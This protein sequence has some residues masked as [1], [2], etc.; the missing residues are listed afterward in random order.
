MFGSTF[1][2]AVDRQA[3]LVPDR[4]VFANS[5]GE[6]LTY[7]QLSER[8][9]ALACWLA[10]PDNLAAGVPVVLYGHKSPN[11]LVSIFACAKSGHPYAPVDTVYPADRVASI[12]EQVGETLVIDTSDGKLD[13]DSIATEDFPRVLITSDLDKA[14]T[15]TPSSEAVVKLPGKQKDDTFY[16]LFTSGS[17]GAPKGVEVTTECVDEFSRWMMEDYVFPEDGVR[18]W[19]NRTPY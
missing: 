18:T 11:M 7:Q 14:Y 3:S 12:I 8:S 6:Q 9:N 17:T 13:W 5:A 1:V 19:F 4:I 15:Q 10:D 2:D 16:I